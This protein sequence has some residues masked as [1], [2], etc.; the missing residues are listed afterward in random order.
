MF[1]LKSLDRI[2]ELVFLSLRKRKGKEK[3]VATASEIVSRTREDDGVCSSN[4]V[5]KWLE[6]SLT[7]SWSRWPFGAIRDARPHPYYTHTVFSNLFL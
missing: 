3:P 7:A 6:V 2:F 4:P 1:R 5:C